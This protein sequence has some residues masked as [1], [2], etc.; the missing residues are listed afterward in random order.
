MQPRDSL[1]GVEKPSNGLTAFLVFHG[2]QHVRKQLPVGSS[3]AGDHAS[4]LALNAFPMLLFDFH[5]SLERPDDWYWVSS[6]VD[7]QQ[8]RA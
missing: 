3:D 1:L 5:S 6:G 2:R 4:T 8:E 7:A